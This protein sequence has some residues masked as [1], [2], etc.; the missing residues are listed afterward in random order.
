MPGPKTA[1]GGRGVVAFRRATTERASKLPNDVKAFTA[2]TQRVEHDVEG[3]GFVYGVL[4]DMQAVTAGNAATVVFFEDGPYSSLDSVVY[5][6]VNGEL[7][8]LNGFDLYLANLGMKQYV[9]QWEDA[10]NNGTSLYSA[11]TGSGGTGGTFNFLLRVPIALNR[12]DLIGLVGNQDRSQK[13]SLRSDFASGAASAT[14]PIYTTAPTT[15]PAAA[16]LDRYYENY[17]VPLPTGPNGQAQEVLPPSFGTLHFLTSFT[18]EAVPSGGNTVNH[19]LRRIG[20]TI[21]FIVLEF[22]SNTLRATADTNAPTSILFKVGEDT[23][24]TE[25]YRYR[26]WLMFERYG[27]D[28]PKGV[29]IYEALHDFDGQGAGG[30]LGDDYFHTQSLV[31]AQFLI[32]YPSGFGSTANTLRFVTDDLI[33]V[34][35]GGMR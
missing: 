27:F 26:R 9:G 28:W 35:A 22:R 30:E 7:V 2:A 3:S 32:A 17:A 24:F 25:S 13:Y 12:R 4:L 6:D 21:R 18:S 16:I 31:N 1:G 15:L 20:N 10:A 5:R 34:P 19:F 23:L 33:Y 8:N 14:G 29:L 11:V